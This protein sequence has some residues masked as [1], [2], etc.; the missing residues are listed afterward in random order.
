MRSEMVRQ[1]DPNGQNENSL[2]FASVAETGAL[3][4]HEMLADVRLGS[5]AVTLEVRKCFPVA[6]RSGPPTRLWVHAPNA[7]GAIRKPRIAYSMLIGG[8]YSIPMNS[9]RNASRATLSWRSSCLVGGDSE[10]VSCPAMAFGS[11]GLLLVPAIAQAA[12]AYCYRFACAATWVLAA[13]PEHLT[14][15]LGDVAAF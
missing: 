9:R 11:D 13:S 1:A 2:G 12:C 6:P 15:H 8:L 4:K 14:D 3:L 10:A 7:Y 5:K